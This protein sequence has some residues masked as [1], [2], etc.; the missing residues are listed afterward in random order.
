[1]S[2]FRCLSHTYIHAC[3]LDQSGSATVLRFSSVQASPCLWRNLH[4]ATYQSLSPF[5]VLCSKT[6]HFESKPRQCIIDTVLCGI[7][8]KALA[9]LLVLL[10]NQAATLLCILSG[11]RGPESPL[12]L[13][14]LILAGS[15]RKKMEEIHSKGRELDHTLCFAIAQSCFMGRCQ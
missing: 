3:N 5:V 13:C 10:L 7:C 2:R 8:C 9:E 6:R 4:L 12:K 14:F 1:M 11:L 15:N